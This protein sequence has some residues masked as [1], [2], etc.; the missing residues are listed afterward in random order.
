M[1]LVGT[2][3]AWGDT[4]LAGDF[5]SWNSSNGSYKF[6]FSGDN[7]TL[8]ITLNAKSTYNF[9]I[10]QDGTWRTNSNAGTMKR[11]NCTG[12]D[13]NTTGGND[14][15]TKIVTDIEGTYVFKYNKST[16][17]LSITYPNIDKV[18][19]RGGMNNWGSDECTSEG[20]G[21]FKKSYS[22]NNDTEFKFVANNGSNWDGEGLYNTMSV[23]ETKNTSALKLTR[24]DNGNTKITNTA[25]TAFDIVI[26]TQTGKYW[27]EE[28]S[29]S[30]PKKPTINIDGQTGTVSTCNTNGTLTIDENHEAGSYKLFTKSGIVYTDKG[31]ITDKSITIE[32]SGT[33]VVR[34]YNGDCMTESDAITFTKNTLPTISA[35]TSKSQTICE[36]SSATLS[37]KEDMTS[38]LWSTEETTQSIN[39]SEAG[40]YTVVAEDSNGCESNT[41]TFTIT[42]NALP[43]A[44]TFTSNEATVCSGVAFNLNEKFPRNSGEAGTLTWYKASDNSQVSD[45]ASVTITEATS[46]YAKATNNNCTS[47]KSLNCTVKVDTKPTLELASTPTVCPNVEIDL[48]DY[49]TYNT[50]TLTWYSNQERTTVITDGLVTPTEQTTYYASASNGVC[51]SEE[52]ELIVKVYEV[53]EEMPAY[54]STPATSCKG[55][56]NSDG[57]I[58]LKN[59]IGGISYQLDGVGPATEWSGLAAGTHKLSAT[60]DAC[61][62]LTSEWDIEVG[63]EDITPSAT[64]TISGETSFCEGTSTELTCVVNATKGNPTAYQW[65]NGENAIQDETGTTYTATAAGNY[66]VVVTVLNSTCPDEFWSDEKVVTINPKPNEPVLSI[67][68]PIC[69]GSNFTLPEEDNNQ[70]NITWNVNDR[71]LT[72]LTAGTHNYTAKIID[73]NG[74]ESNEVTYTITVTALPEITSISQDIQEPVFYEDVTLTATA[75]DGAIVKWYEGGVEKA[76]GTTY[77]VTSETATSK[78]ITAKAFLNGCESAVASHPVTFAAEDCSNSDVTIESTKIEIWCRETGSS[79]AG[80]N[81]TCYA[82]YKDESNHEL[83]SDNTNKGTKTSVTKTSN[84]EGQEYT[85]RVWEFDMQ[86]YGDYDVYVIFKKSTTAWD[87]QTSDLKAGKRN[88]RYFFTYDGSQNEQSNRGEKYSKSES[89]SV[90]THSISAPA[91][92]TVSVNSEQGSGV[93]NFVGRVIKTG[94]ATGSAIWVGYQYKKTNEE[95]P[96]TGVTAGS[97]AKQLVSIGNNPGSEDFTVNVEGLE[98]G[99]YHFRAYIINGYNFTNGNYDQGVYYGLDKLV[100]VSTVQTPVTTATIQLTDANGAPV[101]NDKKYCVGETAYIKV[102]S[103]VKYTDISWKSQQGVDVVQT[104]YMNIY[105]FV[106]KDNDNIVVLL[107]NKH[108]VTPAESNTIEVYT[109]DDPILPRVSLNKFSICSNDEVGATVKLTNVVKGQTYQ[110]YQQIDNGDDTFT[111][112]AIGEAKT[113]TEEVTDKT[114]LVLHT[115]NNTYTTGK[116]FVKTYTSD[117]NANKVATQPFTFTV[118]DAAEVFISIEPTSAETTPWMPAKFT[119]NASDKY[120]LNVT[121][122]NPAEPAT[123]VEVNQ[124]DNKV[125]VKIP[126]PED[127][128]HATG[129]YQNVTFP[130]GATTQYTITATLSA[131]GGDNPC[132]DPASATV[133][134]VPYV[135]EC[136]IGH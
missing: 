102:E 71:E 79:Q 39:V 117:C 26:N 131:T 123:E 55:S 38:Y 82:W 56:P 34:A 62:S 40:T 33:Y 86:N 111:E 105:Q 118:V 101:A 127:T 128:Q 114:E 7:G 2:S 20:D 46:Y 57:S 15:N 60:V 96:T 66:K 119:V 103:D 120:T 77:V 135:E 24:S 91:V 72:N 63:E 19:I 136:T 17:T 16:H 67:P 31:I 90:T 132:A 100:T 5:N 93:V 84:I 92:K 3:S 4:Y 52:G 112:Q 126:L 116:Y 48:D 125:S 14:N 108:N 13:F 21:I 83:N 23:D 134:L 43:S 76:E 50:G 133:N 107:S 61:S 106:V 68:S 44:P 59:P 1:L 42:V 9:K 89:L 37:V 29:C 32:T 47:D 8:S 85:Y 35:S 70:R 28:P 27:I 69:A 11:D 75:T 97:G 129:Q 64:V 51:E 124:N 87:W 94:C 49:A 113:Q 36:N 95:W 18:F 53:P 25:G 130:P 74:C 22:S 65:Y 10:V 121:K 109:F 78:T 45:P 81:L 6:S 12:W 88:N 30:N 110:L 99:D 80:S 41:L 98:D 104:R 115:L 73:V 54:T 58:V 122:G